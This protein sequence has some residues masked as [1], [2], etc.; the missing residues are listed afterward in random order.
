MP[1]KLPEYEFRD[2]D[3]LETALTHRSSG[4]RNNERLEFLGDAILGFLITEIL[5]Q[6]YPEQPEGVLTRLRANLVKRETLAQLARQ[7]D[8]GNFIRLGPGEKKSG[9]WRRDSIL[10]N[11]LESLIGAIYLD[12]GMEAS[13]EFIRSVYSKS[14]Q[15]LDIDNPGKDSKTVLQE[16]LQAKKLPLPV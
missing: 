11:T 15:D 7:L 4:S 14:L 16:L 3:L 12:S 13:S 2:P 8:L 6:A 5:Y 1:L 10:A 9:G